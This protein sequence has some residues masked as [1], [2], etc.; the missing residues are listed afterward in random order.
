MSKHEE[1]MKHLDEQIEKVSTQISPKGLIGL[2]FKEVYQ[3]ME[4]C[5]KHISA[6]FIYY[7]L[8]VNGFEFFTDGEDTLKVFLETSEGDVEVSNF[9]KLKRLIF[10]LREL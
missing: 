7:T 8:S 1:L 4:I 6:G 9:F 2:G 10:N 5:H 3:P